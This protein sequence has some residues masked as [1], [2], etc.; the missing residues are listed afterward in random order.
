MKRAVFV[1][2]L[3]LMFLAACSKEQPAV[4]VDQGV[5]PSASLSTSV[6]LPSAV[7]SASSPTVSQ[8]TGDQPLGATQTV[9]LGEIELSVSAYGLQT[10]P[11]GQFS[12]LADGV[13]NTGLD[14]QVCANY[15][16]P[17]SSERWSLIDGSN[18]R[19]KPEIIS[20]DELTP[21]YPYSSEQLAAN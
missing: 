19:Y 3:A 4:S 16:G 2:A 12:I 14:V 17:V 21:K 13:S 9:T 15:A 1:A 8:P 5:L 20:T 18:G 10:V 7:S 11:R 6:S